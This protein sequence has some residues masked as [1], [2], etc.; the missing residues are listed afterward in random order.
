MKKLFQ[1]F[2]QRLK[3]KKV[4]IFVVRI[5]CFNNSISWAHYIAIFMLNLLINRIKNS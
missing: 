5:R 2:K 4:N 1:I 3:R